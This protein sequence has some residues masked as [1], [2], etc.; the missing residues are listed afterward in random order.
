MSVYQIVKD[1]LRETK[2]VMLDLNSRQAGVVTVEQEGGEP[3]VGLSYFADFRAEEEQGIGDLAK[4]LDLVAAEGSFFADERARTD[5]GF[6]RGSSFTQADLVTEVDGYVIISNQRGHEIS[7]YEMKEAIE[8]IDQNK[9]RAAGLSGNDYWGMRRSRVTEL[10]A[11]AKAAGVKGYSKMKRDELIDAILS[12]KLSSLPET[13]IAPVWFNYGNM[14][15]LPRTDDTFGIVLNHIVEAA[16]AGHLVFGGGGFGP[17]GSGAT[18]FDARDVT[19]EQKVAITRA[20]D[21][22]I[23]DMES[24]EPVAAKVKA[25]LGYYFALGR[26]TRRNGETYYWL[27]GATVSLPSGGRDQPCGYYTLAELEAEKYIDDANQRHQ[28]ERVSA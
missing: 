20:N 8:F 5:K 3:L 1:S 15:V 17:F 2:D 24:L 28:K 25:R 22:Y 13:T 21:E 12:A 16:R 26:P 10:K 6:Q 4:M 18:L 19:E 7:E 9:H 23:E 27:N 14:M 11:K